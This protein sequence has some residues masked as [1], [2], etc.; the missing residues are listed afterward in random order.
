MSK[1]QKYPT[2]VCDDCAK[3]YGGIMAKGHIAT[4][5]KAK[6]GCCGELKECTEPRDY[7]HL[8]QHPDYK[9]N[10]KSSIV[11]ELLLAAML[12]SKKK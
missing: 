12:A 3:K 6:C 5:Y 9:I 11:N 7:R 8:P 2:V 1:K 10:K 4:F